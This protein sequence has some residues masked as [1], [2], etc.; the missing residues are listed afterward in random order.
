[1]KGAATA[2]LFVIALGVALSTFAT[3]VLLLWARA[4]ADVSEPLLQEAVRGGALSPSRLFTAAVVTMLGIAS[5]SNPLA[6]P[7][8]E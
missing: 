8:Q 7:A 5:A 1:M 4:A 2:I 3:W 6:V